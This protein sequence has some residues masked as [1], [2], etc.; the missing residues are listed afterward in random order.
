MDTTDS[1]YVVGWVV[2]GET[3]IRAKTPEEAIRKLKR[4]VRQVYKAQTDTKLG[5][6]KTEFAI[7]SK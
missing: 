6:I 1:T 7:P 4:Q 2:S 3:E 5:T